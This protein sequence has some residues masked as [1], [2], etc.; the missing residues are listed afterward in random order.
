MADL[1]EFVEVYGDKFHLTGLSEGDRTAL[2]QVVVDTLEREI[3]P[4][5]SSRRIT[6]A[7]NALRILS[8]DKACLDVSRY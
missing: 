6:Q 1:A 8:R 2:V 7:L 5:N 4:G 3:T